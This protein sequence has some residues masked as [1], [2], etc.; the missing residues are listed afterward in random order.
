ML[1]DSYL[2]QL[3][4]SKQLKTLYFNNL[5]IKIK[6]LEHIDEEFNS[7]NCLYSSLPIL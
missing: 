4:Q 3:F 7:L 6:L 5:L 2:N 1:K